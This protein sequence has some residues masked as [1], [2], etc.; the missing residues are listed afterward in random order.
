MEEKVLR[1]DFWAVISPS[2]DVPG[3]WVAH[4]LNLDVL[5][6]GNSPEHAREMLADA[7]EMVINDD[8]HAGRDPLKRSAAPKED[9]ELLEQVLTFGKQGSFA[10]LARMESKTGAR[11]VYAVGLSYVVTIH[12]HR[13]DLEER[14]L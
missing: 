2:Q 13:Q 3:Q 5:S 14:G 12:D 8:F 1:W 4:C 9:Y 7:V 11:M 6:Q 10:D